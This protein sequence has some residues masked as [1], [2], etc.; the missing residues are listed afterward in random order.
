MGIVEFIPDKN[1][2]TTRATQSTQSVFF[3]DSDQKLVTGSFTDFPRQLVDLIER[4]GEVFDRGSNSDWDGE[5]ACEISLAAYSNALKLITCLPKHTLYPEVNPDN[6][7]MFD[8][9]WYN[10]GRSFSIYI[11]PDDVVLWAKYFS[12][13]DRS[14]GR[15]KLGNQLPED[16]KMIIH[17]VYG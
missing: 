4:T 11:G 10:E 9:E 14:S 13:V 6:D 3:R 12:D 16:L 5:G 17:Q 8:F 7:G 2:S 1:P 15:F